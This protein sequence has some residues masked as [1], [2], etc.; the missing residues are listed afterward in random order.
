MTGGASSSLQKTSTVTTLPASVL[1]NAESELHGLA[2]AK[3]NV[4]E[5]LFARFFCETETFG[6]A[7]VLG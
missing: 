3:A 4:L 6:V 5:A 2:I 1:N 7:P